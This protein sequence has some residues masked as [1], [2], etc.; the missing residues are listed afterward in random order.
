MNDPLKRL[1]WVKDVSLLPNHWFIPHESTPWYAATFIDPKSL[2]IT[3]RSVTIQVVSN[4]VITWYR[5]FTR[6]A[7]PPPRLK[8]KSLFQLDEWLPGRSP[9]REQS[10]GF[11]RVTG[12]RHKSVSWLTEGDFTKS[13]SEQARRHLKVFKK[14]PG[15]KLRL[16]TLEELLPAYIRSQV[17]MDMQDVFMAE[18]Q[19][20]QIAHPDA[21][22]IMLAEHE[23]MGIIAGFIG[24]HCDE[25]K[26]SLY[27]LGFFIPEASRMHPMLGLVEWWFTRS[28]E[29]GLKACN[30]GVSVGPRSLPF[31]PGNGYSLF[32]THFGAQRIWMPGNYWRLGFAGKK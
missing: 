25:A 31:D 4:R 19:R 27:L 13:W 2:F 5:S 9:T 10:I 32:K 1:R 20:H 22:D 7:L 24:I 17:P 28:R 3:D 12:A 26:Y 23:T 8:S 29:R 6:D 18:V 15:I 21:V 14:T 11:A 16:G 30:F